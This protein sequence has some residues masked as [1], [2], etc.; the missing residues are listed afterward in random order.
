MRP[1]SLYLYLCLPLS[2]TEVEQSVKIRRVI[3]KIQLQQCQVKQEA[4]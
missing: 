1:V 2:L 3:L 4:L